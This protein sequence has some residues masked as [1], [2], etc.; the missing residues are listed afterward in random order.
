MK[1]TR[2]ALLALLLP[3]AALAQEVGS[4]P[5]A[6][7]LTGNER[8]LADQAPTYPC[9][10]C[11]VNLTPNQIVSFL[12]DNGVLF[13]SY[14]TGV[15]YWNGSALSWSAASGTGN[16]STSGTL[17]QYQIP[18]MVT[19]I[20]IG[21]I[22]PASTTG[23]PL[24]SQGTGSYPIFG[25]LNLGGGSSIVTGALPVTNGGNGLTTATLGDL[26]YGSA[27]N[28]LSI[29]AGN[30]TTTRQFLAQTGTGSASAAPLWTALASGDLPAINL[31]ATGAGG[32]IP[33]GASGN[34]YISGGT[35]SAPS[36]GT[37][38]SGSGTVNSAPQYY[39]SY[40]ASTGTAVSGLTNGMTGQLLTANTGGAPS[41]ST[42]VSLTG[43]TA[44]TTPACTDL[45]MIYSQAH[46]STD[47]IT[48]CVLFGS[49][50]AISINTGSMSAPAWT[51][52][53]LAF[54]GTAATLTDTSSSGTV[55]TEAA[56][57]FPAY[58]IAASSATTL[59]HLVEL[60]LPIPLAGTNVTATNAYSLYVAGQSY[61]V[62]GS[63]FQSNITTE[64]QLS[65]AIGVSGTHSSWTTAGYVFNAQGGTIQ[66]TTATGTVAEETM[67]GVAA[68]TTKATNAVTFTNLDQLYIAAPLAGTNVTAT[69]LWS[70]HTVGN[71]LDSG[72]LYDTALTT[73]TNADFVCVSSAGQF[74]IQA[75]ACT[76]S[77][78]SLKTNIQLLEDASPV[79]KLNVESF[80]FK[81]SVIP[82][83]D[84][85]FTHPQVGLIADNVAAVVPECAVYE[86]DMKTPKS[87]RPECIM[88]LGVKVLQDHQRV[89]TRDEVWL[90]LLT[91]WCAALTSYLVI[92][93]RR[94]A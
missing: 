50:P 12:L 35:S 16:V 44:D 63:T 27:A 85:N 15:L 14:T 2:L 78:R 89:L 11:T 10:N 51:T 47:S 37:C 59:T 75:S 82:N 56:V 33:S 26:R 40:Y 34:C 86:D 57:A 55:A 36:W 39:L 87:Y 64:G 13:P 46:T 81:Q 21:G 45:L 70:L 84:P 65:M 41:W 93:A 67:F 91:L 69:N 17:A 48:D 38:G 88:A 58:T 3:A 5:N 20:S 73:G 25:A 74:L 92:A 61:F 8:I 53:G 72:Q 23:V 43:L 66:D 71:V 80:Q 1:L 24:I 76:I 32:V 22:T 77:Q 18:V 19:G 83:H 54:T 90:A 30:T 60:Y 7:A 29:L 6:N 79:L 94:R 28:A 49:T 31:T 42:P 9:L 62:S 52:N 4:Y 68:Y